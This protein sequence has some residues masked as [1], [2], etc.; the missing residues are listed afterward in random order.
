[1]TTRA[2]ALVTT[3]VGKAQ[4]LAEGLRK[5]PG[6][7]AADIVTGAYD[8]VVTL[9]GTDTNAIGRLVM[10]QIHGMPGLKATMTL[11]AVG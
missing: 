6:V 1:M 8:I 4:D 5:L 11:I 9:E 10:N 3:E 2:Y 7:V